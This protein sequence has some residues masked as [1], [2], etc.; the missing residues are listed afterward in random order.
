MADLGRH[1]RNLFWIFASE[2]FR[3]LVSLALFVYLSHKLTLQEN[4][5][6]GTYV[7]LFPMLVVIANAGFYD[8][9]VR[10]IAQDRERR[11]RLVS[12]AWL[13]QAVLLIPLAL[14][15]GLAAHLLGYPTPLRNVLVAASLSAVAWAA[16]RVA[17]A[18]LEG[19]ERF[20]ISSVLNMAVRASI[21]G[22]SMLLLFFGYGV[23]ALVCFTLPVHLLCLAAA[24]AWMAREGM[25]P[26]W[27]P[28]GTEARYL[29][30]EGLPMALTGLAAT[31]YFAM[32]MPI[33][34]ALGTP[35]AAGYYAI[36]V[37]FLIMLITVT[38]ALATLFYPM[39]SRK[40][41]GAPEE[42]A[43]AVIR[44]VK[45][46]AL[47]AFPAAA[48]AT[49]LAQPIAVTLCGQRFLPSAS[50]VAVF[51]GVFGMVLLHRTFDMHLRARGRQWWPMYVYGAAVLVKFVAALY[52]LPRFGNTGLL[53]LNLAVTGA[54]S[55][56]LLLMSIG[57]QP[58][59][60]LLS[61][62]TG[63]ALRPAAATL[64]MAV[65]L[66]PLRAESIFLTIPLGGGIFAVA[67]WL[68]GCIDSFDRKMIR[69]ALGTG[70]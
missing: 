9:C 63:A 64:V 57:I 40:A 61:L 62:F 58:Q 56:A 11:H 36:G 34:T 53:A 66:W 8:V 38:D 46:T 59:L 19:Q 3:K 42:E 49:L 20:A 13:S 12:S 67:A 48:G 18:V 24:L 1:G 65:A 39:L 33:L 5:W 68:L 16:C 29:I 26:R 22:G 70:A 21:V 25:R 45:N 6:Y 27:R 50:S 54:M 4:G 17:F 44:C 14:A 47:L 7:A 35:E 28:R 15:A 31:A 69:A 37:R 43:F 60:R 41:M 30:R 52:V 55:L 2:A 32:D 23:T 10:D 51:T